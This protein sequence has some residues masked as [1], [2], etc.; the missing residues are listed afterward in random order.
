MNFYGLEETPY[1]PKDIILKLLTNFDAEGYV[2]CN[3]VDC[4]VACKRFS[5]AYITFR[6]FSEMHLRPQDICYHFYLIIELWVIT[7]WNRSGIW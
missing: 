2:F 5:C 1:M 4:L 7:P 6:P 3:Y